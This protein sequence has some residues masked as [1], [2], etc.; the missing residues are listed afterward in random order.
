MECSWL[1]RAL[2][3]LYVFIDGGIGVNLGQVIGQDVLGFVSQRAA[4]EQAAQVSLPFGEAFELEF[5]CHSQGRRVLG[6]FD[7]QRGRH[8]P[9][10]GKPQVVALAWSRR[11]CGR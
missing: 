5:R 4:G 9:A 10:R 7:R 11:R 2:A 1:V 6:Q 3:I 8:H